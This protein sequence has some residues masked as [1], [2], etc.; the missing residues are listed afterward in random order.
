MTAP[1]SVVVVGGGGRVGLPLGL[2][3]ADAGRD[4]T[5]YDIN[6]AAIEQVGSGEM[7]FLERGADEVLERVLAAGGGGGGARAGP[8]R[9]PPAPPGGAGV[10]RAR[11]TRDHRG[12]HAGRRAPQ[13]QP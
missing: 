9:G 8:R 6:R 2:A 5:L 13:P 4:V 10:R 3:L 7:P 12:R 11:R 1:G